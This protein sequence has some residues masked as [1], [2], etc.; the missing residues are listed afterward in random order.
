LKI[1]DI[2][3]GCRRLAAIVWRSKVGDRNQKLECEKL[4]KLDGK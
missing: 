3:M 4:R 2:E 1:V